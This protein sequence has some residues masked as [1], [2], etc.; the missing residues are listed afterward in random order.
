M[1]YQN[2]DVVEVVMS[3]NSGPVVKALW[4]VQ[5]IPVNTLMHSVNLTGAI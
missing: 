4:C 5:L 2:G 3:S 1:K